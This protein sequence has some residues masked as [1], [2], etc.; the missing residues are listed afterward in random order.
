MDTDFM[1]HF[2]W[3]WLS[4]Q[5]W[6]FLSVLTFLI[7]TWKM[8]GCVL[9]HIVKCFS[10]SHAWILGRCIS[11]C[12]QTSAFT[13]AVQDV[14]APLCTARVTSFHME[15]QG[16]R[17]EQTC[18]SN[19]AKNEF[20]LFLLKISQVIVMVSYFLFSDSVHGKI[21]T[22]WPSLSIVNVSL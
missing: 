20:V 1:I 9:G 22:K 10:V 4:Q 16:D 5:V 18:G 8:G 17:G 12:S 15:K 7:F 11:F 19:I 13:A 21:K 2:T 6:G 3:V 14:S